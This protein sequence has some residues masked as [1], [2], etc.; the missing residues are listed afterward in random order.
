L[1]NVHSPGAGQSDEGTTLPIEAAIRSRAAERRLSLLA[2]ARKAHVGRDTLYAWFD[3]QRPQPETLQR[4][5]EVLGTSTAQLLGEEEDVGYAVNETL[6]RI[7]SGLEDLVSTTRGILT[8]LATQ[9]GV[10][11]AEKR[12]ELAEAL[13]AS[14]LPVELS[15]GPRP[16]SDRPRTAAPR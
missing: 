2:L 12:R 1:R 14:G 4:V 15:P 13:V 6:E 3:G 10:V 5:A 16:R 11:P 9:Q 8:I 7:A